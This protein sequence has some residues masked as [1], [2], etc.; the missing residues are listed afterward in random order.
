MKK[1]II[2][3]IIIAV[4]GIGIYLYLDEKNKDD[5]P[6]NSETPVVDELDNTVKKV[7]VFANSQTDYGINPDS[8]FTVTFDQEVPLEVV[9]ENLK[10]I[11]EIEFTL[12]TED[13]IKYT[14]RPKTVLLNNK[15]YSFT[16]DPLNYGKAFQTIDDIKIV[17]S[18]PGKDAY[19]VPTRSVIELVF[20]TKGIEDI[21]D[22][23]SIEPHVDGEF[24]YQD[25]TV[26]FMP[27]NLR[28][29]VYYQVT[30][31]AGLSIDNRVMH[32]DYTFG[33]NTGY[34][35]NYN[36]NIN[37]SVV[38]QMP[39][40]TNYIKV[41]TWRD[42]VDFQV[43]V[44]EAKDFES[45]LEI[46]NNFIQ[47][48]EN[49]D[50]SQMD[51]VFD[52]PLQAFT[53]NY[54]S[55]VELPAFSS[56]R[57]IVKI[58]GEDVEQYT[59]LQL[60][61][62]QIYFAKAKN[63]LFFWVLDS[64]NASAVNN[65][66]IY[67]DE[68]LI[69]STSGDGVYFGNP[70]DG[71]EASYY[72]MRIQ[73][74]AYIVNAGNQYGWY[75]YDYGYFTSSDYWSF[76]YSDRTAYLPTDEINAYGYVQAYD[77]QQPKELKLSLS[78]YWSDEV[79]M[80]K[81]VQL[82][83]NNSYTSFLTFEDLPW[84]YYTLTLKSGDEIIDFR[85]VFILNYEK[86]EIML[87]SSIEEPVVF[88]GEEIH[89]QVKASYF[90]EMPYEGMEVNVEGYDLSQSQNVYTSDEKG[91][92]NI[93]FKTVD[94][95]EY[96]Y[97]N[98]H[99]VY[100]NNNSIEGTYLYTQAMTTVL[101]RHM[102]IL[103]D[104]EIDEDQM[105]ANVN[106][107]TYKIDLSN[108]QGSFGTNYENIKGEALN[109]EVTVYIT[110]HYYEKIF[111]KT[112]FDPIHKLTYDVYH[113]ERRS[114]VLPSVTIETVNGIGNFNFG[115]EEDHYYT[116]EILTTDEIGRN[117]RA[118]T[119]V[120]VQIFRWLNYSEQYTIPYED[121]SYDI[122]DTVEK[123]VLL[124]NDKI[125]EN[126]NDLSLH[127]LM[128]DGIIA[129]QV[130]EEPK[131]SFTFEE[132]HRPNM[133]LK[134][135]YFDGKILHIVPEY[136][137][138][139]IPYDY[140]TLEGTIIAETD[141]TLYSPGEAL[142]LAI[143]VLDHHQ[144]PF[145][146]EVNISVVD[147][148]FFA[149]YENYF[150]LGQNLHQYVYSDG[151]ISES[152]SSEDAMDTAGAE[153]GEGGD[154]SFIREDFKDTAYFKTVEVINGK[155]EV[156]FELPD[157]ITG[158]RITL[159]AV[160]KDL[161]YASA[162]LDSNVNLP[163][164]IRGLY[165]NAYLEGDEVYLSLKSDGYD[166]DEG[167]IT[168][169][170]KL[171]QGG[172]VKAEQ[173]TTAND[174]KLTQ[175]SIGA[176]PLGDY[177]LEVTGRTDGYQDGILSDL[178]V[179]ETYERFHHLKQSTLTT[180]FVLQNSSDETNLR[181]LNQGAIDYVD[182]LYHG[183]KYDT[184]RLEE[185]V[186]RY[187]VYKIMNEFLNTSYEMPDISYFQDYDGGLKFLK[188]S[189]SS[190]RT[191]ALIAGTKYGMAY[192]DQHLILNYLNERLLDPDVTIELKTMI[193]WGLAS[194]EQPVLLLT[195]AFLEANPWD[196]LSDESKLYILLTLNE[197]K[198][199]TRVLN[200]AEGYFD[201]I[202]NLILQ[203]QVL[204]ATLSQDLKIKTFDIN[205]TLQDSKD[206]VGLQ[207]IYY[208]MHQPLTFKEAKVSL[209]INGENRTIEL[210]GLEGIE[211]KV[212]KDSEFRILDLEGNIKVLE[213]YLVTG[214]DYAQ[215]KSQTL[216]LTRNYE[217]DPIQT[218][219]LVSVTLSYEKPKDSY[220]LIYDRI[221]AGFEYAGLK[222]KTNDFSNLVT[223]QDL[224]FCVY[225]KD[226]VGTIE[227]YIKAVQAGKYKWEPAYIQQY[228]EGELEMTKPQWLEVSP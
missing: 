54:E 167:L 72:V 129:Y 209:T 187:G 55:Y 58:I 13:E 128:R 216:N 28:S 53:Y 21:S 114:D 172:L 61:P 63:G 150:D 115:I 118:N 144:R 146:G 52:E 97:P 86:P 26:V 69:G 164:F 186:A 71:N 10:I 119:N 208:L 179:R 177:Q 165:N 201:D 57:Y 223:N 141:K 43:S 134:T 32:D 101:P 224:H 149:L 51:Q 132:N 40:Q 178:I 198:D 64:D 34:S 68:I 89:Y 145:N 155:A 109:Q 190:I 154:N 204:A 123:E 95:D 213:D 121:V 108:Y 22:Y 83:L 120:G 174:K 67:A 110:D 220:I 200:L 107:G 17:Q 185:I 39:D 60:D 136:G 148:A 3:I 96:W 113:Y 20:N 226:T 65:A 153:A 142:S 162:K 196:G 30:M 205:T 100:A 104:Y 33:F 180:G 139:L 6:I 37:Y 84:G 168:Y 207:N 78:R 181:F 82:S 140:Q 23:F 103:S 151:I 217:K 130:T 112:D 211:V 24:S 46:Y 218:G 47:N 93:A 42:P 193:L 87:T 194:Q 44:Y 27:V 76:L 156:D 137:S 38:N 161:E 124:Y 143:T 16:Y 105:M 25:D 11:P 19:D 125:P 189:D 49:L 195:D 159:N 212:P 70:Q 183:F 75:Y 80:E 210:P 219:D 182:Q 184:E 199:K 79:V 227:Y 4:V 98:Y 166:Y 94:S 91:E 88:A 59:F 18:F 214:L 66:K 111:E 122:G 222:N 106:L 73:D 14:V 175:V 203:N 202:S 9:N 81:D 62:H 138:V 74:K 158:W 135:I 152:V 188:T 90:N 163:F 56:G 35:D 127:L 225:S 45:Y 29:G 160:N 15:I 228:Y 173:S 157:N 41:N 99:E 1:L 176:L 131:I 50:L 48:T 77:G 8:S 12:T 92:I 221:P 192:F 170:A 116:L 191:T 31:K 147:E 215:H 126:A 171:L 117:V 206:T 85:E 169:T 102:M 5:T 2:G 133:M 36:W 7:E 197:L